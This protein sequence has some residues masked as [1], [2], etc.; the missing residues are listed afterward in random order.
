MY[1]LLFHNFTDFLSL[2]CSFCPEAIEY[3][4]FLCRSRIEEKK[5][6]WQSKATLV[7]PSFSFFT[8]LVLRREARYYCVLFWRVRTKKKEKFAISAVCEKLK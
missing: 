5:E 4:G 2:F 7:F 6:T 8:R 3:D 1:L